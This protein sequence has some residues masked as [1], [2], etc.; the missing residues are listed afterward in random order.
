MEGAAAKAKLLAAGDSGVSVHT[1]LCALIEKLLDSPDPTTALAS[2]E[3]LSL[4][5]K[6]ERAALTPRGETLLPANV[7]KARLAYFQQF[8]ELMEA[9]P[10]PAEYVG[11][12][13]VE[14]ALAAMELANKIMLREGVIHLI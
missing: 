6:K 12:E 5:V 11:Q 8:E 10:P 9:L 2:L 7:I 3:N 1:H 13:A 4:Q 14:E